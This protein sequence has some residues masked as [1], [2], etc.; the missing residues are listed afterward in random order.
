[1]ANQSSRKVGN[2][3]NVME[4]LVKEEVELQ[5]AALQARAPQALR[6]INLVELLA[7]AMNHLPSLYATSKKGLRYQRQIGK[8]QYAPQIKD[9]VHRALAT[10]LNDPL[11]TAE[12]LPHQSSEALQEILNEVRSLLGNPSINWENLP[13]AIEQALKQ[14]Q[15]GNVSRSSRQAIYAAARTPGYRHPVPEQST[16]ISSDE[17]LPLHS[18]LDHSGWNEFSR[19]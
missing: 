5:L 7:F 2:Y 19:Y 14:A 10:V 11:R 3:I 6:Q 13:V 4:L 15:E 9:A 1:M 8:T 17:T 18:P 12:P 16:S